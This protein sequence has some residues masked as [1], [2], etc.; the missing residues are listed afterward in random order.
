MVTPVREQQALVG[1]P[2]PAGTGL[3]E[4]G[5]AEA[6][7]LDPSVGGAAERKLQGPARARASRTLHREAGSIVTTRAGMNGSA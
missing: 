7:T 4:A 6:V 2:R 3:P 1:D 5:K